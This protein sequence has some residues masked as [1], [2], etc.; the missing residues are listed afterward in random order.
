[1][2]RIQVNGPIAMARGNL[3]RIEEP[4]GL[5][6]HVVEGELWLTQDGS[7]RDDLL[8]AGQWFRV[9]HG[10]T[11]ILQAF[12]HSRVRLYARPAELLPRRVTLRN[13]AVS[14]PKLL[15]RDATPRPLRWLR[16]F[17]DGLAAPV[18]SRRPESFQPL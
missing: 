12:G 4:A 7:A 14:A 18:T 6:V 9:R 8:S 5:L 10:G 16:R 1:M 13:D 15:F 17:L 3:L 2:D 11:G